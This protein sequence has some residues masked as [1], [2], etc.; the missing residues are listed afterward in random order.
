M[1]TVLVLPGK[2]LIWKFIKSL[3]SLI[4]NST[5]LNF[6]NCY[7]KSSCKKEKVGKNYFYKQEKSWTYLKMFRKKHK[8]FKAIWAVLG[9]SKPKTSSV[10]QPWWQTFSRDLYPPPTHTPLTISVLLRPWSSSTFRLYFLKEIVLSHFQSLFGRS[11]HDVTWE[12]E[13]K[14]H[15]G[16]CVKEF[17]SY[18]CRL[19]SRNFI[20]N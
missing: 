3:H 20:T 19:A 6:L 11:S 4:L 8:N 16:G 12:N 15:D 9:N 18:N 17:F 5:F 7:E 13:D 14:I 2:D 10:R 1:T